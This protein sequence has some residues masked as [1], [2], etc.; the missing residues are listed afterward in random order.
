MSTDPAASSPPR[1]PASERE[2]LT[3][4]LL[5]TGRRHVPE[6]FWADAL[7]ETPATLDSSAAVAEVRDAEVGDGGAQDPEAAL[8]D[9]AAAYDLVR[10]AGRQVAP[11]PDRVVAPAPADSAPVLPDAVLRCVELLLGPHDF[12]HRQR[13][14][15]LGVVVEHARGRRFPAHLLPRLFAH[16]AGWR[17]PVP[18]LVDVLGERGR[19]LLAANRGWS[20]VATLVAHGGGSRQTDD[21]D[22][23]SDWETQ[24]PQLPVADA[25]GWL[26]RARRHQPA[27]AAASLAAHWPH[28]KAKDRTALLAALTDDLSSADEAFLLQA[29]ADSSVGVRTEALSLLDQLGN[30]PRA[31]RLAELLRPLVHVHGPL[32]R[33]LRVDLPEAPDARGVA[34]GLTHGAS[35]A[36]DRRSWLTRIMGGAPLSVWT[37]VTGRSVSATVGMVQDPW[38]VS[39]LREVAVSRGDSA[40][41]DALIEHGDTTEAVMAVASAERREAH[42]LKL[43]GTTTPPRTIRTLM[44]RLP[45]P[46]SDMVADRFL[47]LLAAGTFDDTLAGGRGWL[48]D[49]IPTT[50]FAK[51]QRLLETTQGPARAVLSDIV[52]YQSFHHTLLEALHDR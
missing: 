17:E 38:V 8:L 39:L 49:A 33:K 23:P 28:Y 14:D 26:V 10:R 37:E 25:V 32:R 52:Q 2:L 19:W 44:A 46:W 45:T 27:E 31:H 20:R 4:A 36:Q 43:M 51:V 1:G 18:G 35:G 12:T 15:L 3:A 5:G 30:G 9:A 50:R 47:D 11:A 21:T 34:D 40:W 22:L 29:V 42:A 6:L 48:V 7:L 13:A 16:L 41:A 24:W